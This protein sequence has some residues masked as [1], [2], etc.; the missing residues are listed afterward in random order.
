MYLLRQIAQTLQQLAPLE[1][2]EDWDN[3]GLLLGSWEHP[4]QRV[5]T[6]LTLTGP[7]AQE[8][9][10]HGA[11]LVVT[12]HPLPFRPVKRI[13]D[14][15]PAGRVLWQLAQAGICIY[16][17]HTAFDSAAQGINQA[18]A[19][20]IGLQ[21]ITPL[22]PVA[23]QADHNAVIAGTGRQ[24]TLEPELSLRELVQR[25]KRFLQVES[26]QVVGDLDFP[27]GRVGIVCGSG[28]SL[29]SRAVEVG[30]QAFLTGEMRFHDCLEA[31]ARGTA[32]I[33]PGHYATERFAMERLAQ[34]LAQALPELEVWCSRQERDPLQWF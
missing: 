30:C 13:T 2:A 25:V 34:R 9:I 32:V 24:G 16:S 5:I 14:E 1:L 7:V 19:Q 21:E 10:R 12:H 20:G 4:V 8:A 27:V 17:A 22:V 3:V 6:C 15:T 28:G 18:L 29:L 11:Q 26:L 33:L 31:Q 23:E